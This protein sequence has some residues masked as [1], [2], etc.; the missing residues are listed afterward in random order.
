M[1]AELQ[2]ELDPL[3]VSL[4]PV[5]LKKVETKRHADLLRK[6]SDRI[7]K[8]GFWYFMHTFVFLDVS[9]K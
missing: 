7:G 3:R 1:F 2:K 4:S 5:E 9:K 8:V 6:Y